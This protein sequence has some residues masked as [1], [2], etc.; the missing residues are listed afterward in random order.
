LVNKWGLADD[1][2]DILV[3]DP[4]GTVIFSF[5]G[6]LSPEA[7]EEMLSLIDAEIAKLK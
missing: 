1:S 2:N 4:N 7:I 6:Q 5:D 3:F